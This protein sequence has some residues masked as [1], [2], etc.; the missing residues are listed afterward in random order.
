MLIGQLSQALQKALLGRDDADIELNR[1]DD[2]RGDRAAVGVKD[3]REDLRFVERRDHGLGDTT[4]RNPG[5]GGHGGRRLVRT[6]RV[7][8]GLDADQHVVMVPVVAALELDD[9]FPPGVAAGDADGV[10]GGFSAGVAEPHE[11]GAK[12]LLDLLGQRDAIL[13]RE[14]VAGAVGHAMLERLNQERMRMT[15]CKYA[16]GHVEVDVLVAV[17]VGDA[18][19]ARIGHEQ[20]IGIVGLERTRHAERHRLTCA[21]EQ[22]GALR[23]AIPV[24]LFL[25]RTDVGDAYSTD[26]LWRDRHGRS[27]SE[28]PT[29]N[30]L[31]RI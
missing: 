13:D 3:V 5:A 30:S 22:G 27:P 4:A 21:L 29:G 14:R 17:G 31:S 28:L 8:R 26:F 24:D 1:L 25:A 20:R 23:R 11:I 10:H 15:R 19:P 6:H 9:L 7:A 12:A 16:E 2:D 18:R